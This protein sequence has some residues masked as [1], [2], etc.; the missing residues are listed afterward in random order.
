M[1]SITM[2]SSLESLAPE[3][4]S[5][6][7]IQ[8]EVF[9]APGMPRF[10]IVG[11]PDISVQEAKERVR[12]AIKNSG[13]AFPIIRVTVS[14]A[15]AEVRK[16]G[17][18]FDFPIALGILA[19]FREQVS[20]VKLQGS[21][22]IGELSLDGTLRRATGILPLILGAR[23]LGIQRAYI[24]EENMEEAML[25]DGIEI[26][27]IKSLR[28]MIDYLH[29]V[30][31]VPIAA[32]REKIPLTSPTY[33][34]DLSSIRGQEFAKRAIEISAAGG[35]N[36]LLCGSPG[37]GKTLLA[38]AMPSILPPM[39]FDESLAVTKIYS[40]AGLLP[41]NDPLISLRPFRSVHHTA[42]AVAIVGGG[43]VP[44]PGEITL[45]HKGV[46]FL[47]EMAE[48]PTTVLEVLRQPM[49]DR[50]ITIS[51]ANGSITFP[52]HFTL[53]AAMNPCPCG[54]FQVPHSKKVCTCTPH[55]IHLYQKKISGPLLD[56]IDLNCDVS[57]IS[58]ERLESSAD[59]ENSETVRNRVIKAR[60]AQKNR[61]MKHGMKVNS[62]MSPQLVKK[63]AE[64]DQNSQKLLKQ[65][66]EKFHL[67]ARGYF[68]ILKVARTIADLAQSP[69]VSSDHI[70]EALQYRRRE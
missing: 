2:L 66:V 30:T 8:V 62:E 45:A 36:L 46:L 58:Y 49:E 69:T 6:R 37:S 9:V 38:R 64:G 26:I 32:S 29:G 14:L 31:D 68:K 52:A 51:R 40:Y 42:S 35:H 15:P 19:A 55:M 54:Y 24:P 34:H 3:A 41:T 57:P 50:E 59:S 27:P 7:K 33:S 22:C 70:A 4:L 16:S 67:S 61:L 65:A 56:R 11:L 53:V 39:D 18:L 17:P 48:F 5:A 23:D 47:D 28:Q 25:I 43:K 10:T 63:Y 1:I 12:S 20:L 44:I 13:A 21:V 60:N